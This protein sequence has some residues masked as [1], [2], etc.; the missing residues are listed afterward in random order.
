MSSKQTRKQNSACVLCSRNAESGARMSCGDV[1]CLSCVAMLVPSQWQRGTETRITCPGCNTIST[2]PDDVVAELEGFPAI[3]PEKWEPQRIRRGQLH[4]HAINAQIRENV[5]SGIPADALYPKIPDFCALCNQSSAREQAY[6]EGTKEMIFCR[7]CQEWYCTPCTRKVHQSF[8]HGKDHVMQRTTQSPDFTVRTEI[9]R[10][11]GDS[12]ARPS[13]H[14]KP[15]FGHDRHSGP[16]L[17]RVG[18]GDTLTK[19][20]DA[21]MSLSSDLHMTSNPAM[22][23]DYPCHTHPEE[24][25]HFWCEKCNSGGICGKCCV[26]AGRHAG[27]RVLPAD[28]ALTIIAHRIRTSLAASAERTHVELLLSN[29]RRLIRASENLLSQAYQ[30]SI[31]QLEALRSMVEKDFESSNSELQSGL[32]TAFARYIQKNLDEPDTQRA[33]AQINEMESRLEY[34]TDE[35]V[36]L[37]YSRGEYPNVSE[38]QVLSKA[39]DARYNLSMACSRYLREKVAMKLDAVKQLGKRSENLFFCPLQFRIIDPRSVKLSRS[40]QVNDDLYEDPNMS[41]TEIV[42]TSENRPPPLL[43]QPEMPGLFRVY[44]SAQDTAASA[45]NKLVAV[46][47][48]DV[49]DDSSWPSES[50]A[51]SDLLTDHVSSSVPSL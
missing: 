22:I 41:R 44:N 24:P 43:L 17:S 42:S 34:G 15:F 20:W 27:H 8:V 11:Q 18:S 46:S 13:A 5:H 39:L 48:S 33:I 26:D 25:Q 30:E 38:L 19:L 9:Y 45:T 1:L 37:W 51:S 2:L 40:A 35:D 21:G 23:A 12:S 50:I 16:K 31:Q 10:I 47:D 28:R 49:G 3:V 6:G 4:T 32:S 7:T 14:S 29:C 36:C